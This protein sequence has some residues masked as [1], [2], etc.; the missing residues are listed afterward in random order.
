MWWVAIDSDEHANIVQRVPLE[1]LLERR[2]RNKRSNQQM[3]TV[4][5]CSAEFLTTVASRWDTVDAEIKALSTAGKPELFKVP[6]FY[7]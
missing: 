4:V 7:S 1:M 3:K 2:Y 5:K 6:F